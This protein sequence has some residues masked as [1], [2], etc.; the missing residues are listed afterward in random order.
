[1]KIAMRGW[2]FAAMLVS[3]AAFADAPQP[4]STSKSA[5]A[6]TMPCGQAQ[7]NCPGAG[8]MGSGMGPG[9]GK[10][11]QKGMGAGMQSGMGPGMQNGMNGMQQGMMGQGS[12]AQQGKPGQ[13]KK[14]PPS[15]N[16]DVIYGSQLMT[17]QE[18]AAYREKLRNAKTVEERAQ[19][20][21]E[22][23]KEM[24]ERA[25][26]LGKTLPPPPPG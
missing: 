12:Q 4:A 17:A 10:G 16:K 20:R 2:L 26:K 8:R 3:V 6:Q 18:R 14:A 19:I 15:A 9:M 22:H 13:G 5:Q 21:A 7:T 23:H 25:K 1:M 11:M 24:Q